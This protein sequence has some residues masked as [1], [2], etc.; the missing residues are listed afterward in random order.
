MAAYA[1]DVA[2]D[3]VQF[4]LT[5]NLDNVAHVFGESQLEYVEGEDFWLVFKVDRD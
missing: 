3:M 1:S 2:F 4:T 5:D